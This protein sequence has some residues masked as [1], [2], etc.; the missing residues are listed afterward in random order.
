MDIGENVNSVFYEYIKSV[1]STENIKLSEPMSRHTTFQVGGE[2]DYFIE[3]ETIEQLQT[4]ISYFMKTGREYYILGNGSNLLVS[5]TGYRGS[6]IKLGDKFS[7]ITVK[8]DTITA[9]AGALLSAVAINAAAN[10][11]SGMEFAAG[12]PGS[13]GGAIVMNAGAFD[14]EMSQIVKSVTVLDAEG[15]LLVFD[16]ATMEFAYRTSVIKNR[17]FVVVETELQLQ[18][19]N[20]PDIIQKMK[21]LNAQRREKQPLNYSSAGSTFQRPK[22]HFAGKLIMDAGLRGF[23]IGGAQVSEKHCGFIINVGNATASDISELID[24]VRERVKNQFGVN[25]EPEVIRLGEF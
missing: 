22:G 20:Q 3:V 25:L 23:R 5:D 12:I 7:G 24:E 21:Q 2:A 18:K 9:Q 10:E 6:I 16:N 14:G 1:V 19:S 4:L 8:D 13:I 17:K 15:N 11:L